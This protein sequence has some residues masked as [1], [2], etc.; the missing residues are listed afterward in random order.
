MLRDLQTFDS[1]FLPG[2]SWILL[3]R[4]RKP[5]SD[6]TPYFEL[7][8]G[9]LFLEIGGGR[10]VLGST[11]SGDPPP[12]FCNQSLASKRMKEPKICLLT[13]AWRLQ[14]VAPFMQLQTAAG[15]LRGGEKP[16]YAKEEKEWRG[17]KAEKERKGLWSLAFPPPPKASLAILPPLLA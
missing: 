5:C 17:R 14:A 6:P 11:A 7:G 10:A 4:K 8:G 16:L 9:L 12:I 13:W 1:T 2:L 15:E 3:E